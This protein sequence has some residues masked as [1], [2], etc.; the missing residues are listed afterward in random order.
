MPFQGAQ[1]YGERGRGCLPRGWDRLEKVVPPAGLEGH[2]AASVELIQ[3]T[4]ALAG[5]DAEVRALLQA[6][7]C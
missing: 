2:H 1:R 5:L 7:R 3:N 6:Y 4:H